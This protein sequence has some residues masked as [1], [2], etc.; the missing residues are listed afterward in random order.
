MSHDTKLMAIVAISEGT[1]PF[2]LSHLTKFRVN[3]SIAERIFVIAVVEV[4]RNADLDYS[5]YS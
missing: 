3:I 5:I 2:S 1:M 4:D